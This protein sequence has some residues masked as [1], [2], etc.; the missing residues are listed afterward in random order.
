[1]DQL[2]ALLEVAASRHPFSRTEKQTAGILFDEMVA[3]LEAYKNPPG[4]RLAS[5][6]LARGATGRIALNAYFQL[7]GRL[8]LGP[9]YAWQDRRFTLRHLELQCAIMNSHFTHGAEK[10]F[11]C[12][13]TCTL[14]VLPLYCVGAFRGLDCDELKNNVVSAVRERKGRMAA[15]FSQKYARWAFR[16]VEI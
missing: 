5:G 11:Y 4:F 2:Y 16:F 15:N 14:S 6:E 8:S 7:L 12:C 9:D 10:G 1:M 3:V 13:P